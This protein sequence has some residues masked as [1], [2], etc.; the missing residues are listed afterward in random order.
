MEIYIL[1]SGA[2]IAVFYLFYMLFLE[3]T[4]MHTFKRFYLLGALLAGLA[5]PLITFTTYIEASDMV[6]SIITTSAAEMD[7]SQTSTFLEYLPKVLWSVYIAGALFFSFRFGRN[8]TGLLSK[9][10]QNQKLRLHTFIN[11]LLKDSVSPHTFFNYIFLN[12]QKFE[13]REIPQEILLHEQAHARQKH[14]MDILFIEILQVVFWFN[15]FIYLIKHSIKLNHE[16]L[17]D[18]AVLNKGVTT[19]NYQ[20]LLLAF[21]SNVKENNLANAINYSFIKKRFTVM[22]TQTSK[23]AFWLRSLLLLPL[24]AFL[25]FSFSTTQQIEIESPTAEEV[26]TSASREEMAEYTKLAKKYNAQEDGN[27]YILEKEV[28]RL[29][30]IYKKMSSKQ[31]ANAEPFPHFPPP[32]NPPTPIV[33]IPEEVVVEEIPLE[34]VVDEI[35]VKEPDPQKV[36]NT[37]RVPDVGTAPK[38]IKGI[39]DVDSNIPPPPPVPEDPIDH[40]IGM[41]KKNATFYYE[42]EKISSDKAISIIK[43]NK[44]L[45]IQ[46]KRINSKNPVVKISKYGITIDD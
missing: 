23:K 30:F 5:I 17:A 22:K 24:L 35:P 26:Q 18:R 11:V 31:R 10:K 1:K 4:T 43:K 16:F 41:A 37:K 34:V 14:S 46:T 32:P 9:I 12:K 29:K 15:P 33:D 28:E 19:A 20:N 27:R 36:P 21:S 13:A 39:N 8:L 44:R 40:I 25:L 45:N 6:N 2:C 3:K 42:D 38:V 7:L